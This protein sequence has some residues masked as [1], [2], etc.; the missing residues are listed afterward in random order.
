[1][2]NH[3][4]AQQLLKR[5]AEQLMAS[6]MPTWVLIVAMVILAM[7]GVE[8]AVSLAHVTVARIITV[9]LLYVG[10]IA[11]AA[12]ARYAPNLRAMLT[13]I[14]LALCICLILHLVNTSGAENVALI[15]LL[16]TTLGRL[17]LRIAAVAFV[18]MTLVYCWMNGL[19]QMLLTGDWNL[20]TSSAAARLGASLTVYVPFALIA[21]SFNARAHTT[22]QLRATQAQLRE[23]MLHT[24]ELAASRER[25]RIARDIH[26]VLAHTLTVLSVQTQAARQIVRQD[27]ERAASL[28]DEMSVMLRES[29]AES[30][31]V[32]GLLRETREAADQQGD[33]PT[34]R[35]RLLATAEHFTERAGLRCDLDE[36]GT[37]C[38][39]GLEQAEALNFALQEALTNAYRH[40][41]AHRLRATL[42]WEASAVSLTMVDDG[43]AQANAESSGGGQGL[44][45]MRERA[46]A[47]DGMVTAGPQPTGGFRVVM[48]LPFTAATLNARGAA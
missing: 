5:D 31:K 28:L 25:A 29:L 22:A 8:I 40:G 35:A 33:Y 32:V 7:I 21:G 24:S 6:E 36:Q 4:N 46:E 9:E 47:L 18:A 37:P 20:F 17:P 1:M 38:A 15:V 27:P 13:S 19:D 10:A 14:A 48:R 39:V 2:A 16:M 3:D 44:R 41:A 12:L 11:M 26:D 34:L 23:E 30:R 42:D 45:G 43:N